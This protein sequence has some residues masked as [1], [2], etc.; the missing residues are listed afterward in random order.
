MKFTSIWRIKQNGISAIKF[1][2]ARVP[3]LSDNS[4]AATVVVVVV[5]L[6][7]LRPE[8]LFT[9]HQSVA[10]NLSNIWRSTFKNGASLRYRNSAEVTVLMCE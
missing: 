2:A 9:L 7:P 4:V 5:Y 8:Y 6:L 10:Q 3:F 1:E